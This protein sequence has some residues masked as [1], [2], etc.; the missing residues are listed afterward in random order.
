MP[1]QYASCF[2]NIDIVVFPQYGADRTNRIKKVPQT[3][4]F[5]KII[6]NISRYSEMKTMF[7][8]IKNLAIYCDCY[9]LEYSSSDFAH[10]LLFNEVFHNE[11][12]Y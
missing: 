9:E 7:L 4:A 8:D 3:D 11:K 5:K 6:N 10:E 2:P 1:P 12:C